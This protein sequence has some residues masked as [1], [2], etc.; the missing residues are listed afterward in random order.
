MRVNRCLSTEVKLYL[1][2]EAC[3]TEH[4]HDCNKNGEARKEER[5]PVSVIGQEV[6]MP[7][8]EACYENSPDYDG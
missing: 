7:V 2:E 3:A 6:E 4:K 5:D 1:C 8:E